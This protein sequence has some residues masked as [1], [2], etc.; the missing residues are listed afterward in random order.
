MQS[1]TQVLLGELQVS[2]NRQEKKKS[3]QKPRSNRRGMVKVDDRALPLVTKGCKVQEGQARRE[4][5]LF[6]SSIPLYRSSLK[7][8]ECSGS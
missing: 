8:E 4:L 6:R 1:E 7:P 2:Q 5:G 3:M